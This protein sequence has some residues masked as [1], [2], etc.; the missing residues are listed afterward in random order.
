M[1]CF[2][3]LDL[4]PTEK[5]SLDSWRQQ[6]LPEVLPRVTEGSELSP[7]R[8]KQRRGSQPQGPATPYAIP[9][10]N[11]H[12]TLCFLGHITPSQ[13]EQVIAALDNVACEPFALTLDTT[14]IW[15]G[16][17]ILFA[18]PTSPPPALMQLARDSRKAARQAGI[19]VEGREYRPHVTLI[20]KAG[21]T[22]PP[23]LY[24]PD[25]MVSAHAFHLFESVSAPSGVTYPIRHSW[26]LQ[27]ATSVR[28]KLRRGLLD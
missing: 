2:I 15:N 7:G 5:L 20:R 13:H 1:R 11:Y 25:C 21:V 26:P 9:A 8:R 14:G 4:S 22:L 27:A 16:P 10:A 23:P 17:K 19:E 6:A 3:G 18:A 24:P 28:E 12:I